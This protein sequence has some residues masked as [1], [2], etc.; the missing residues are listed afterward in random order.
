MGESIRPAPLSSPQP[1]DALWQPAA[2]VWLMLVGEGVAAVLALAWSTQESRWVAFG[3]ASLMIQWVSLLSLAALRALRSVSARWR[4]PTVAWASVALIILSTLLVTTTAR[5]ILGDSWLEAS[6]GEWSDTL[7]RVTGIALAVGL[8]G[9]AAFRVHW[10]SRMDAVRAKQA[11]LQALQARIHPHFL[12]NTLNTAIALVRA[13]PADAEQL[14]LDLA[15]LFRAA[16]DSP[17]SLQLA[18]ELEL[19]RR[20]LE[21]ERLR[22]GERLRLAWD[23]PEPLPDLNV[24]ALC[25]QPLVENAVRHGIERRTS[26]GTLEVRVEAEPTR[27]RI[28]VRNPLADTA[29]TAHGHRIGQSAVRARLENLGHGDARLDTGSIDGHYR[30]VL[31]FPVRRP[32]DQAITR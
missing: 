7:L 30:A 14:L 29:G 22:L 1:L 23:V 13:R 12:F 4:P 25:I 9:V 8:L 19:T 6:G 24:P 16:L 3:V 27:V 21:I 32:R 18:E 20:Y 11:E 28:S 17:R 26:G 2:L 15:D 5:M 10:H 31:T